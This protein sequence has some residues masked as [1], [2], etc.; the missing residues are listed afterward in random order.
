MDKDMWEEGENFQYPGPAGPRGG[1]GI[2]I[3]IFLDGYL[4]I[5]PLVFGLT[6]FLIPH[7]RSSRLDVVLFL[8]LQHP[9]PTHSRLRPRGGAQRGPGRGS[10]GQ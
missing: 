9:G 4:K 8:L 3:T 5:R 6:R 7:S 10:P 2:K 1:R